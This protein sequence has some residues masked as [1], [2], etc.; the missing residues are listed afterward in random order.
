MPW[1]KRACEQMEI[2]LCTFGSAVVLYCES[3]LEGREEETCFGINWSCWIFVC[4]AAPLTWQ[5]APYRHRTYTHTT[6]TSAF[7]FVFVCGDRLAVRRNDNLLLTLSYNQP[8]LVV[9]GIAGGQS[10]NLEGEGRG[11]HRLQLTRRAWGWWGEGVGLGWVDR[12]WPPRPLHLGASEPRL[13][14]C[15]PACLTA[16]VGSCGINGRV[17]CVKTQQGCI[18]SSASLQLY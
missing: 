4:G 18:Q 2:A 9:I 6:P 13:P 11:N 16:C 10:E 15:L 1:R 8:R 17:G 3:H 5:P 7:F 12:L 14:A